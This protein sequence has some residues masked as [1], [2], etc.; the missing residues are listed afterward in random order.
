MDYVGGKRE[1]RRCGISYCA[2]KTHKKIDI[3]S[4]RREHGLRSK[5][6]KQQNINEW[7]EKNAQK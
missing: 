2:N 5:K 7:S 1:G 6:I 4:N 3:I